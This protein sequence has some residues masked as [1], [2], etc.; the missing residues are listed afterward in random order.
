MKKSFGHKTQLS[1]G[2]IL[3]GLTFVVLLPFF[4]IIWAHNLGHLELPKVPNIP[5]LGEALFAVGSL[6]LISGIWS[7][8]SKGEGLPM[9]A[10]PPKRYVRSGIFHWFSH[11][12]YIGFCIGCAG[13]S[14]WFGSRAGLWVV[15]P[16]VTLSCAALVWGY[17]RADL[18]NRFG[19]IYFDHKL[20]LPINSADTP[21]FSDYISVIV[22]VFLPWLVLYEGVASYIG[23]VEPVWVSTLPFEEDMPVLEL[24][25]LPYILTYPI[26]ILVPLFA[27]TKQSLRQF[28]IAGLVA[29]ALVIPFYLTLPIVA[30]FRPLEPTTIWGELIILQ[31]SV[32]NPATA[33]PAFHVIWTFLAAKLIVDRFKNVK[34]IIWGAAWIIAISSWLSGMHALLDVAAGALVYIFVSSYDR[35]W[36]WIRSQSEK[37]S[38]S[39]REWWLG[40]VRIINHGIYVGLSGFICVFVTA[41]ILGPNQLIA[42]FFICLAGILIAGLWAQVLEGSDR[43]KR[44]FGYYGS[45]LGALIGALVADY[46][47]GL[48]WLIF[49]GALCIAAPWVQAIGRLRC[50]VQGCCHGSP[51]PPQVGITIT[52]PHSRVCHLAE[53]RGTPIHPTPVYSIIGNLFIGLILFRL[54]VLS[55]PVSLIVGIYLIL[56]SLSRFVEESFRGEPQTP[57]VGGLNVYQWISIGCLITGSIIT[58]IP[59]GVIST[60]SAAATPMTWI[61]ALIFGLITAS[62]MGVDLPNSNKRFTRLT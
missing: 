60:E 4:L 22:L 30:E 7:I 32:D 48:P 5:M 2:S 47:I 16:I 31:H 27:L 43:L 26:V 53:L 35:V 39:W 18:I 15:T 29:I 28:S 8:M 1:V 44:P 3:Y 56:S 6:A 41:T 20:Q 50:L 13:L 33:F 61:A 23:V 11:P 34:V 45:V 46:W 12:I 21:D 52:E 58:M 54:M 17:E 25:G 55:S 37:F 51:A 19:D 38:N 9:N 59:S 10:Y 40:P 42:T 57:V 14:I 49:L 62:L 36:N 24:A